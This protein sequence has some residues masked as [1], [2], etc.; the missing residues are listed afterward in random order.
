MIVDVLYWLATYFDTIAL[1][2]TYNDAVV[3]SLFT[4]GVAYFFCAYVVSKKEGRGGR[5][6]EREKIT[7]H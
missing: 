2:L 3:L 6:R 4:M 1:I 7:I 5:G